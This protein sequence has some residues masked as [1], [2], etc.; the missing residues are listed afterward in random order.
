MD[1]HKK[2][3]EKQTPSYKTPDKVIPFPQKTPFPLLSDYNKLQNVSMAVMVF[4][5]AVFGG[6]TVIAGI[7]NISKKTAAAAPI[8]DSRKIA[9]VKP[10]QVMKTLYT[11]IKGGMNLS[12]ESSDIIKKIKNENMQITKAGRSQERNTASLETSDPLSD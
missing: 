3:V 8:T 7:D 6:K 2:Q 12:S 10:P 1:H 5:F 11:W 9:T 4:L